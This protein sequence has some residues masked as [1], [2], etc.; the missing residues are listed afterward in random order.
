MKPCNFIIHFDSIVENWTL[1]LKFIRKCVFNAE[2][3]FYDENF[4]KI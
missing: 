1:N 4:K 2:I 3:L